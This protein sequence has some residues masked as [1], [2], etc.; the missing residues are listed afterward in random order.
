MLLQNKYE[1]AERYYFQSLERKRL[2]NDVEGLPITL[3]N[4]S[5]IFIAKK[6]FANASDYLNQADS[7]ARSLGLMQSLKDNLELKMA[8]YDSL[9]N[10]YQ[11]LMAAKELLVVKDSM[12]N[13]RKSQSCC[14]NANSL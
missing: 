6:A 5:K 10:P 2:E 11:A 7:I 1:E 9:N 14:R 8:L 13:E 12:L 3:N 4:V